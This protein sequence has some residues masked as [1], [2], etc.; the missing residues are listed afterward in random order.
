MKL[1]SKA[2]EILCKLHAWAVHLYL[3][4]AG[5]LPPSTTAIPSTQDARSPANKGHLKKGTRSKKVK[6]LV[7]EQ[8]TV[9]QMRT[10]DQEG[11]QNVMVR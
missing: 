8:M 3:D 1:G 10:M 6:E 11:D 5:P 4:Y 9:E 2:V 7:S